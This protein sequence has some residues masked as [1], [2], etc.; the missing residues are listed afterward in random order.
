[1]FQVSVVIALESLIT[2]FDLLRIIVSWIYYT[3]NLLGRPW[4]MNLVGISHFCDTEI[5]LVSWIQSQVIRKQN[6]T[7]RRNNLLG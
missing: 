3:L 4:K 2:L 5:L 1:M 6:C 7:L